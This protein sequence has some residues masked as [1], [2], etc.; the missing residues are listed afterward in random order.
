LASVNAA[1]GHR[2][3][4]TICW[5]NAFWEEDAPPAT[6]LARWFKCERKDAV[7]PRLSIEEL[8]QITGHTGPLPDNGARHAKLVKP[9]LAAMG[10]PS[11]EQNDST[12]REARK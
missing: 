1:S 8:D 4:A 7:N 10:R 5:S 2:S 3:D 11:S 12:I 9:M 6:L